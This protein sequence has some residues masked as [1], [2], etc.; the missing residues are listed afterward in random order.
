MWPAKL[1]GLHDCF[2]PIIEVWLRG[3]TPPPPGLWPI[4][5]EGSTGKSTCPWIHLCHDSPRKSSTLSA[6]GVQ[7]IDHA[8]ER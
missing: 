3:W 4:L 7:S 8:L 1:S 5:G 6:D 2:E